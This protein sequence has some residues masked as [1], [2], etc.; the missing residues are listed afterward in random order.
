[1]ALQASVIEASEFLKAAVSPIVHSGS[2]RELSTSCTETKS[3][4]ANA[5][6]GLLMEITK[7]M[8]L[9]MASFCCVCS[10]FLSLSSLLDAQLASSSSYL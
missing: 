5:A 2:T 7:V 8:H 9:Q 1:M 6:E 10:S 3:L 4:I